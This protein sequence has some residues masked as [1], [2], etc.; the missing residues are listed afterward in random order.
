MYFERTS[1]GS[2][3]ISRTKYSH[4]VYLFI[5]EPR[6]RKRDKSHSKRIQ[7]HK[8]LSKFELEQLINEKPEILIIGT[9]Q[10]GVL[11]LS[12]DTQLWLQDA[13]KQNHIELIRDITPEV[14]EKANSA[15]GSKKKVVG[16]FHTTC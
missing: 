7:G 9:G 3:T 4:D 2:I 5:S 10:S 16:I 1:F 12:E 14:L 11:P 8:E 15:L 13:V 6:I